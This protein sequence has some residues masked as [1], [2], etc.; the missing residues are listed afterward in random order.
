M[1]GESNLGR[2]I[3]TEIT[4]RQAEMLRHIHLRIQADGYPPTIREIGHAFSISSL[5]GVTVTLDALERK[6]YI[7]RQ[8][9]ARGIKLLPCARRMLEG[10]S[11]CEEAID[12]LQAYE[13]ASDAW[14][15]QG[16]EAQ[17]C[18]RLFEI[19]VEKREAVLARW[20][21]EDEMQSLR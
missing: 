14:N 19:A 18:T 17:M 15:N 7:T 6:G 13:N 8:S 5:R 16:I 10:P 9:T 1:K 2:P 12:A 4:P 21:E 11:L 3:I 20:R